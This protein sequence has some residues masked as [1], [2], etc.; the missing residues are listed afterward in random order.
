MLKKPMVKMTVIVCAVAFIS[1]MT[2][3]VFGAVGNKVK[4]PEKIYAQEGDVL[5]KTENVSHSVESTPEK[6]GGVY[7]IKEEG[8]KVTISIDDGEK[9][10][11]YRSYDI[12]VSALPKA[13]R[14]L[15]YKG[16]ETESLSDALQI[17]EDYL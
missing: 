9:S 7:R 6:R 2:G 16:I 12:N 3:Y 1:S 11:L 8:G 15:L 5:E 4:A 17:I 13:D 14:E 10:T